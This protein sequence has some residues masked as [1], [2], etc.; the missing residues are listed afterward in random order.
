[1]QDV[2]GTSHLFNVHRA[3]TEMPAVCTIGANYFDAQIHDDAYSTLFRESITIHLSL[4]SLT[5][6]IG[7][8][9]LTLSSCTVTFDFR[10]NESTI[11]H[12]RTTRCSQELLCIVG[13][14]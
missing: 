7:C 9:H 12:F 5:V 3:F 1:M 14:L 2:V 10:T 4:I 6:N 11:I 13:A 8:Y